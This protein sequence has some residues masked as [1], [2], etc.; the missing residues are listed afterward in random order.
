MRAR[1]AKGETVLLKAIEALQGERYLR[2][3]EKRPA[4]EAFCTGGWRTDWVSR[5][6]AAALRPETAQPAGGAAD[7]L[8]R[9]RP[10]PRLCRGVG[11]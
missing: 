10:T 4:N 1:G 5:P 8:S 6:A 2:L 7:D 11:A 3:A 9:A